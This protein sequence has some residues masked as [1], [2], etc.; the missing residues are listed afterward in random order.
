MGIALPNG[1]GVGTGA[2]VAGVDAL[3]LAVPNGFGACVV[4]N[5]DDTVAVDV[6]LKDGL[7]AA[8]EDVDDAEL[9][10]VAGF[11]AFSPPKRLALLVAVVVFGAHALLED[12]PVVADAP[13]RLL[14]CVVAGLVAASE[15]FRFPNR[16]PEEG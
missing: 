11:V 4:V 9:S 6:K 10:V 1:L 5:G 8:A 16:P 2:V 12:A 7:G 14:G 3:E 13:N 15:A